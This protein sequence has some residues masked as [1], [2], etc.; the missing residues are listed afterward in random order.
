LKACSHSFFPAAAGITNSNARLTMKMTV[1]GQ[2]LKK[3]LLGSL[4]HSAIFPVYIGNRE[5]RNISLLLE[6]NRS[7]LMI[8]DKQ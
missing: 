3:K 5:Q 2:E 8:K 1:D 6:N 4:G 7:S